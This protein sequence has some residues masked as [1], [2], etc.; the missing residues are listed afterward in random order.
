MLA[1]SF[2]VFIK[3]FRKHRCN[4][5]IIAELKLVLDSCTIKAQAFDSL[6]SLIY[7]NVPVPSE[8]RNLTFPVFLKNE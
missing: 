3:L 1:K 7:E 4:N 5:S 2:R 6:S 8:F